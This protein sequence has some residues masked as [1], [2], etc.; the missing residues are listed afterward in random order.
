MKE[1]LI[2]LGS[3]NSVEGKLGD[4]AVERLNYCLEIFD[5]I[6]NLILCTG[7]FG[8][9]FNPTNKPHASYAIEH[10]MSLGIEK[11]YFM[12]IALSS[13]TV[14]DAVKSNQVLLNNGSD[15]SVR[16]ITSD[17][18]LERVKIVFDYILTGFEKEYLGVA[19]HKPIEEKQRL[20]QHEK[21]AIDEI[22]K[23]GIYF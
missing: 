7:G 2:V 21:R 15:Y 5:P 17:F 3:P 6:K 19:H 22:R 20:I 12:D 13:N 8:D 11:D 1:V 16:I 23:N 9:H 14:E 10:L 4:I 18:H